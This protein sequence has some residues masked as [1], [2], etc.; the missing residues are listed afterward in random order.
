MHHSNETRRLAPVD[1]TAVKAN[2]SITQLLM[3][4]GWEPNESRGRELRGPCPIHGSTFEKSL[5]F[6]VN[7]DRKLY[8]CFK[9]HAGGDIIDLAA[10]LAGISPHERVKAAVALCRRLGMPVPR[11]SQNQPNAPTGSGHQK[12]QTKQ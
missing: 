7:P 11:L 3:T 10:H 6:S 8:R 2:A 5:V 4:I 1:F 9:C 12:Q